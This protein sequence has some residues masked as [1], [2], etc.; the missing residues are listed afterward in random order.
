ML[1]LFKNI[2]NVFSDLVLLHCKYSTK[3]DK[4]VNQVQLIIYNNIFL[5]Q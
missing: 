4:V 3:Y 5:L 1:D 2:K